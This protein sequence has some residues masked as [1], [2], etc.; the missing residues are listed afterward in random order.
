MKIDY[1]ILIHTERTPS[2]YQ[3]LGRTI[4]NA[5]NQI[6]PYNKSLDCLKVYVVGDKET[7]KALW[8]FVQKFKV[9]T[10]TTE[11]YDL[12]EYKIEYLYN[13][14]H[15]DFVLFSAYDDPPYVNRVARQVKACLDYPH[16]C[17]S[18]AWFT[19][20]EDGQ[21]KENGY[22][23]EAPSG[24]N[25]GYPSGWCLNK[26]VLPKIDW[27]PIIKTFDL[28]EQDTMLLNTLRCEYP[29]VS[30]KTA[31][32]EY[33]MLRGNGTNEVP[34]IIRQSLYQK[35]CVAWKSMKHDAKEWI[36]LD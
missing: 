3:L 16:A 29:M 35:A 32:F 20:K 9:K 5:L 11:A 17:I 13:H 27:R 26:K 36:L 12:C 4:C 7:P 19:M 23:N 28:Y 14:S 34:L 1:Y 10:I 30:L 2:Q 18:L 33:N 21:F 22:F 8:T 31:L 25:V 6:N 15:A 24:M